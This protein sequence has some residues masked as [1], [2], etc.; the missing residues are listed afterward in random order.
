MALIFYMPTPPILCGLYQGLLSV[1]GR[2]KRP[3]RTMGENS[4]KVPGRP[5]MGKEFS[6]W[7]C[8]SRIPQNFLLKTDLYFYIFKPAMADSDQFLKWFKVSFL[9]FRSFVLGFFQNNNLFSN[10]LIANIKTDFFFWPVCNLN[11][12]LM[13]LN[14][15]IYL[16]RSRF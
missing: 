15:T 13:F 14:H 1:W 12:C 11:I 2:L 3:T 5:K 8:A 9:L 7:P 10:F 4:L 16:D 6:K